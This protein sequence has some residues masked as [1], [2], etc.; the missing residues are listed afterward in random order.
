VVLFIL[1]SG[2]PPFYEDERSDLFEKIKQCKY[3][4][5]DT[6]WSN[7]SKEAKDLV[8]NILKADPDARYNCDQMLA[9]PWM[10]ME[11]DQD[12]KLKMENLSLYLLMRKEMNAKNKA[13]DGTDDTIEE[14]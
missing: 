11:L 14:E 10:N 7:I 2:T 4:F 8:S 3:E 5:D 9:H 12:K 1:L 6:N 13:E